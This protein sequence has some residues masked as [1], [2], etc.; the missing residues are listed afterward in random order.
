MISGSDDRMAFVIETES[1]LDGIKAAR[2]EVQGIAGDARMMGVASVA[3]TRNM[4]AWD[5]MQAEAA[6]HVGEHSLAIGRLEMSLARF[7]EHAL[8]VN[9]T[10]GL[11]A[12]SLGKFAIGSIETAGVLAGIAAMVAVWEH[13][14]S[15]ANKATEAANKVIE[16]F[17]RAELAKH[18]GPEGDTL[19]KLD[20]QI[21]KLQEAAAATRALIAAANAPASG[22]ASGAVNP[23]ASGA[24]GTEMVAARAQR[25]SADLQKQLD[26]DNDKVRSAIANR[27][28]IFT[29]GAENTERT[30]AGN[31]ATLVSFN[32]KDDVARKNSLALIRAYHFELSQL[33][34][35]DVAKRAEIVGM[36]KTLNAT[37]EEEDKKAAAL[38]KAAMAK[39][40]SRLGSFDSGINVAAVIEREQAKATTAEAKGAA[41]HADLQAKAL[42]ATL[43]T[44]DQE[45]NAKLAANEAEYM[46]RQAD[47]INMDV[48]ETRK[49]QLLADNE[50]LR[51]A[52]AAQIRE[53][54]RDKEEKD[55][56]TAE[57]KIVAAE[58]RKEAIMLHT[59]DSYVR[60]SHSL[61]QILIQAALSPLIK[62]L[63]GTAVR[64]MVRAAAS[65]AAGDWAG[66][67]RHAAAGVM[68]TAGAHE[69]AQMGA[70]AGSGGG[71]SSGSGGG[72]FG[73][74]GS[75]SSTFQP[76]GSTEGQGSVVINLYTQNPYG[77]EQIQQLR[78]HLQRAEI[79]K[80]PILIT[81]TTGLV[82]A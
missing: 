5:A 31:L 34:D 69:V 65:A 22:Q 81:P 36:I 15:A 12:T 25:S 64:Q 27:D 45:T 54:A 82:K 73:G 55:R 74:S 53:V 11:L 44:I 78:Y 48:T 16:A 79:L 32:A 50:R 41:M 71:G 49:T 40:M 19:K 8:G 70:S 51:A 18:M 26:D 60:S 67:A 2:A 52:T 43:R 76:R 63:E 75:G 30:F 9:S 37:F 58:K 28:A 21:K 29:K 68:A 24:I 7:S 20:E 35:A 3:A 72:S 6:G 38:E 17:D 33:G 80:A 77:Y 61:Q 13:F 47:I 14:T 66:A 1:R 42:E 57:A 4:S 62:E 59:I 23:F 10:L 46:R 56:Q 39:V